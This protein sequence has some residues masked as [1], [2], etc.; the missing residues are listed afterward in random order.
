MNRKI[1]LPDFFDHYFIHIIRIEFG[2]RF[3][4]SFCSAQYCP[5]INESFNGVPSRR[6][7]TDAA[8][9][10]LSLVH[11]SKSSASANPV[12]SFSLPLSPK[13]IEDEWTYS[14]SHSSIVCSTPSIYSIVWWTFSTE[15]IWTLILV[16]FGR[17][18]KFIINFP[19]HVE[20]YLK[21]IPQRAFHTRY[22]DMQLSYNCAVSMFH[23]S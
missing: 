21:A 20:K 9:T 7:F 3:P 22:R 14:L 18:S 17:K 2:T 6:S 10:N 5:S 8:S 19:I 16:K 23:R 1:S 13:W 12:I 4:A 15:P 11:D